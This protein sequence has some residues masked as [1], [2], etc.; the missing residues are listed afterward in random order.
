MVEFLKRLFNIKKP[1]VPQDPYYSDFTFPTTPPPAEEDLHDFFGIPPRQAH[2]PIIVGTPVTPS[3]AYTSAQAELDN[4][5]IDQ[6]LPILPP[7]PI[8]IPEETTSIPQE[9]KTPIPESPRQSPA[10]KISELTKDN[11]A[12]ETPRS[13]FNGDKKEILI[14]LNGELKKAT[15]KG[16]SEFIKEC[17]FDA[18]RQDPSGTQAFMFFKDYDLMKYVELN[19]QDVQS[20]LSHIYLHLSNKYDAPLNQANL[21]NLLLRMFDGKDHKPWYAFGARTGIDI[22]AQLTQA[23]QQDSQRNPNVI[24]GLYNLGNSVI[25]KMLDKRL[26]L[27]GLSLQEQSTNPS[28]QEP[29]QIP[30]S[31]VQIQGALQQQPATPTNSV[32]KTANSSGMF[33]KHN[34]PPTTPVAQRRFSI[35]PVETSSP[36]PSPPS[37]PRRNSI[38]FTPPPAYSAT[39]VSI[40]PP[41][42]EAT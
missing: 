8:T 12:P 13:K 15:P 31:T 37:S 11:T 33:H 39:T 41:A 24:D 32:N 1:V 4:L 35:F 21:E 2:T 30:Q 38:V 7:T 5:D 17:F 34:Q 14:L 42:V 29:L 18:L 10:P 23:I 36:P 9:T 28:P 25:N 16:K 27:M 3:A 20:I 22:T 26:P 19:T 6:P 40:A